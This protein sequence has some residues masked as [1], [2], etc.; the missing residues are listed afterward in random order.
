MPIEAMVTMRAEILLLF[1][2][3]ACVVLHIAHGREPL[4]TNITL[5]GSLTRM[6]PLMDLEVGKAAEASAAFTW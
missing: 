4:G 6:S 2:M 5:V 3:S 1:F